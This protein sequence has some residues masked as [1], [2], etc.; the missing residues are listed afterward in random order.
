MISLLVETMGTL[1]Y[2]SIPPSYTT[3]IVSFMYNMYINF[4]TNC[5]GAVNL[6][7]K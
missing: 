7:Y 2:K 5:M 3:S 4:I 6:R 1:F